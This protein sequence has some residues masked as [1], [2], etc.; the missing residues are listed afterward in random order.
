[1]PWN[2]PLHRGLEVGVGQDDV[3]ALAAELERHP[4][5]RPAALGADLAAHG[6]RA[7]EGHLVDAGVVDQRRPRLAVAGEHVYRAL[8]EAGL[9]RQL[10]EAKAGQ[11]RL[12]GGLEDQ[13]TAGRQGRGDLP[14]R[15]QQRK[16]PRDDLRAHAHRLAQRVDEQ[17]AARG[18]DRLALDLRRPARVVAQVRHRGGDVALGRRQR[19]AVVERLEL[20]ELLAVCLDQLGER[21]HQP[22]ALGRRDLAQR[23]VERGARGGHRAVDVL[24]PRLGDLADRLGGRR[25]D[26]LER[27]P[28]GGLDAL[29]ADQEGVRRAR[30]EFARRL[31]GQLGNGCGGH[32]ADRRPAPR[33]GD[34][35]PAGGTWAASAAW[36]SA[37]CCS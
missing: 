5:Q 27:A 9:K 34:Q 8:R 15:H 16:V 6:G 25:V 21:V 22:G 13:R 32:G 18:R 4:L 2:E 31:R 14:H 20:G 10:A 33:A 23:A 3:R 11:R 12:L 19:L 37:S 26:R 28:V 7:G 29:A 35:Q 17:V 1:M 24:G 30:D 36:Y